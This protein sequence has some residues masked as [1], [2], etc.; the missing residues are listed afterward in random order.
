M[1]AA[2][3]EAQPDGQ[4]NAFQAPQTQLW[5]LVAVPVPSLLSI[6]LWLCSPHYTPVATS[7]SAGLTLWPLWT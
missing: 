3:F 1:P 7:T 6:P 2:C 5:V 4:A